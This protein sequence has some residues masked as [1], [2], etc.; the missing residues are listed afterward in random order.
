LRLLLDENLPRQL[1]PFLVGHDCRTVAGM[2]W[3]GV[4]N[5]QLLGLAEKQFDIF[6]T[7]DKG[8]GTEQNL[9]KF[10]LAIFLLRARRNNL[11][12]LQPLVPQILQA[13]LQPNKRALTVIRL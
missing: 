4:K 3:G 11:R 7:T 2:S 10:D 8:F 1:I 12:H 9:L 6:L 13:A 5:G